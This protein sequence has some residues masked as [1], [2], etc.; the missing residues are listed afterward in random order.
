MV[1]NNA[2]F[3]LKA[4]YC[5]LGKPL[6]GVCFVLFLFCFLF[7]SLFCFDQEILSLNKQRSSIASALSGSSTL[8]RRI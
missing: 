1:L 6:C 8:V 5:H 3:Y 2:S 4:L 7:F